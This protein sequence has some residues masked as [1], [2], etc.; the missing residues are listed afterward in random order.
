MAL[1]DSLGLA[2]HVRELRHGSSGSNWSLIVCSEGQDVL[3]ERMMVSPPFGTTYVTV[4]RFGPEGFASVYAFG[5]FPF[6]NFGVGGMLVLDTGPLDPSSVRLELRGDDLLHPLHIL[7]WGIEPGGAVV[8]LTVDLDVGVNLSDDEGEGNGSMPLRLV[9]SGDDDTLCDEVVAFVSLANDVNARTQEPV[10]LR[11]ERADGDLLWSSG[12]EGF[13]RLEQ[14]GRRNARIWHLTD[15]G[16]F[17]RVDDLGPV[18]PKLR[19][20]GPDNAMI[21][22]IAAFGVNRDGPRPLAVPL[23]HHVPSIAGSNPWVGT[24]TSPEGRE[25]DLPL[26]PAA[27]R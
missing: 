8:P 11:V 4:P 2:V 25:L 3:H 5:S 6:G 1:I 18:V 15:N 19:V 9:D 10:S 16:S 24:S 17:S 27:A 20:D 12:L 14:N 22:A 23:V 26:C 13:H 7:L 21:Q